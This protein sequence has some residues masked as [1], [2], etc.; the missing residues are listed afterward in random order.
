MWELKTTIIKI[1]ILID[2]FN[3]KLDTYEEIIGEV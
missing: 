2:K 3:S 1:N